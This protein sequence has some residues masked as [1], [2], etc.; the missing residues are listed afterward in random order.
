MSYQRD[1]FTNKEMGVAQ[2]NQSAKIQQIQQGQGQGQPQPQPQIK[3]VDLNTLPPEKREGAINLLRKN[4]TPEIKAIFKAKYD[5]DPE[6]Y[7]KKG[8]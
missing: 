3:K 7:L 6:D 8:I 4:P 1:I 2:A 5:V